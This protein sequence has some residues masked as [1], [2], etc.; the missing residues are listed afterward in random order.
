MQTNVPNIDWRKE[1]TYK[2][3]R[4]FTKLNFGLYFSIPE[5]LGENVSIQLESG[6]TLECGLL[7]A[8][9]GANSRVREYSGIAYRTVDYEQMSIVATL[10]IAKQVLY[11]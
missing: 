6:E 5:N 4:S 3:L 10:Q 9:D 2:Q 11:N 7:I 8:A 1:T